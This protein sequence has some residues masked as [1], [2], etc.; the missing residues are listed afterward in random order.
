LVKASEIIIGLQM[1]L[2]FD[3]GQESAQT[4][5]DFYAALD[6]RIMRLQRSQDL[7]ECEA[8]IAEVRAMADIW[9]AIDAGNTAEMQAPE[10]APETAQAD[11][12]LDNPLQPLPSGIIFSAN[13]HSF[14]LA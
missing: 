6:A 12:T 3:A 1:S 10:A 2:D 7:Q 9:E 13:L 4:L 11:A 14:L 5:Y 8:I